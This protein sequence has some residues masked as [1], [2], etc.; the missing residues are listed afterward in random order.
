MSGSAA[1]G[2]G[3][4]PIRARQIGQKAREL[5]APGAERRAQL[6]R[7]GGSR[8]V[9]ERLDERPVRGAH[10][11]VARAVENERAVACRL[12]GELADEPAL[13]GAGLAAEQDDAAAL[14]LRPSA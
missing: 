4:S 12:G 8:Q 14:A 6:V 3:S 13:A 5:A 1:T 7:I 9:V 2:G 11:G 10:D